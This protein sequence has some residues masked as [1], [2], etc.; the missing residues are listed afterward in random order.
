MIVNSKLGIVVL[1]KDNSYINP[2]RPIPGLIMRTYTCASPV[3]A[4]GAGGAVGAGGTGGVCMR[5]I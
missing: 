2:K 3:G 4:G 1:E 5:H